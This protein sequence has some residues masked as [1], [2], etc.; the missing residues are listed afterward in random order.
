[1]S[2]LSEK[3][4]EEIVND[5]QNKM[6]I[7]QLQ[8][9]Y[10]HSYKTIK[11]ILVEADAFTSR[12]FIS[13]EEKQQIIYD[14]LH[15]DSVHVLKQKYHHQDT[16]IK[17]F[18]VEADVYRGRNYSR[19]SLKNIDIHQEL[20]KKYED[21][22]SLSQLGKEYHLHVK[23]VKKILKE[24]DIEIRPTQIQSRKYSVNSDFFSQPSHNMWY[25]VG[26]IAA[27][28]NIAKYSNSLD[29][30]LAQKDADILEKILKEMN[31]SG[32]VK[33]FTPKSGHPKCRLTITDKKIVTDL[34]KY[35]VIRAKTFVYKM[36]EIPDEFLGDFLRG[37]F[38]GDGWIASDGKESSIVT[39]SVS[40]RDDL[41]N[42]Y[43]RLNI[44]YRVYTDTRKEHP[45]YDIRLFAKD[46]KKFC[47]IIY[48]GLN[49]NS[50]FLSRKKDRYFQS[51]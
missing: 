26:F 19:T 17:E 27:D 30:A 13:E 5:Y 35:N 29:I 42:L 4:K 16:K 33:Y 22:S 31:F 24:H 48:N 25:I 44:N 20:I 1:M 41:L 28:G 40:F 38:D 15:G 36:P 21:G 47:E 7:K 37:Y 12:G 23:M 8:S 45:C 51:L 6:T 49:E 11:S 43:N 18:L 46:T 50:L 32:S 10:H 34:E 9:K 39:A 2:Q 14:Y 3:E